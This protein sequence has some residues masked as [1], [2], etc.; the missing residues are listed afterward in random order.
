ME[1]SNLFSLSMLGGYRA[2]NSTAANG[3]SKRTNARMKDAATKPGKT[4]RSTS[5][6]KLSKHFDRSG[7]QL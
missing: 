1:L 4:C 2:W 5:A 7:N 3:F 6:Q